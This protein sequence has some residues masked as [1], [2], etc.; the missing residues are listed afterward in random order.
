MAE[1]K[2]LLEVAVQT[3][4]ALSEEARED[5]AAVRTLREV[6]ASAA[7]AQIEAALEESQRRLGAIT[8]RLED[9]ED[10]LTSS[11]EALE[12]GRAALSEA[13]HQT[14]EEAEALLDALRRDVEELLAQKD[15]RR[16]EL[17]ERVD[18]NLSALD[19]ELARLRRADAR[20]DERDHRLR[21]ALAELREAAE[22]ASRRVADKRHQL[23]EHLEAIEFQT[24]QAVEAFVASIVA[25][26]SQLRERTAA[27]V[28]DLIERTEQT[29]GRARE[30]ILKDALEKLRETE[31]ETFEILETLPLTLEDALRNQQQ[32]ME[33]FSNVSK[34]VHDSS[35]SIIRKI[36]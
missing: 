20:L 14:R 21:G 26:I 23:G 36:G 22:E 3:A 11:G 24:S 31:S 10:Q 29:V 15:R 1:L 17:Q 12:Q 9:W 13:A 6:Q 27:T 4:T 25:G 18:R 28:K 8:D 5:R 19:E 35:L 34:L 33:T 7:A 2:Q 32:Q 16:Q 30:E